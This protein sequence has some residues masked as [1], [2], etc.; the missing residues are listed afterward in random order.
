MKTRKGFGKTMVV[1]KEC[2]SRDCI[3]TL[4]VSEWRFRKVREYSDAL[5]K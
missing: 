5:A 2:I 1:G 3:G 4:S